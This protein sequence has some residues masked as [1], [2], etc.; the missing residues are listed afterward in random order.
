MAHRELALSGGVLHCLGKDWAASDEALYYYDYAP[1][2]TLQSLL[3]PERG[4][5]V[6]LQEGGLLF[7]YWAGQILRALS[8]LQAQACHVL[9]NRRLGLQN[10]VVSGKGLRVRLGGLEWGPK[11]S[12]YRD[13]S[14]EELRGRMRGLM[15]DFSAIVLEMLGLN[16]HSCWHGWF[17]NMGHVLGPGGMDTYDHRR[18][19]EGVEVGEGDQVVVNLEAQHQRMYKGFE[20]MPLDGKLAESSGEPVVAVTWD[21]ADTPIAQDVQTMRVRGLRAG[22]CQ[23]VVRFQ[24][25]EASHDQG[26]DGSVRIVVTVRPVRVSSRLKAVLRSCQIASGT[27]SALDLQ[28]GAAKMYMGQGKWRDRFSKFWIQDFLANPYFAKMSDAHLDEVI[29]EYEALFETHVDRVEDGDDEEQ[30][31]YLRAVN[32]AD[33]ARHE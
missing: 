20:V 13:V 18:A 6:V 10:V 5:A 12:A 8:G 27:G 1:G 14:A 28:E 3:R 32:N 4:E 30:A 33:G 7:R 31:R 22:A 16:S 23:I 26:S 11:I 15:R 2:V 25:L 24:D 9:H 21:E 19:L 29:A 17:R